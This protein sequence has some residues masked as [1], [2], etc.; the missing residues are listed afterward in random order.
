MSD[1]RSIITDIKK[2]KFAPV[3][4]LM[5]EEGYYIDLIAEALESNVVAEEDKEFDSIILYGSDADAASVLEAAGRYPMLSE[6]FFVAL[7]EAQTMFKAKMQMENLAGYIARPN[8]GTI[9]CITYKGDKL[10]STSDFMKAVKKNKDI[11]FFESPKIREYNM[12]GVVSDI[13]RSKNLRIADDAVEILVSFV[14][15]SITNL[16]SELDKLSLLVDKNDPV[17]TSELVYQNA[18]MS[19]EFNDFELTSALLRRDYFQA[20]RIVKYFEVNP[21]EN[22]TAKTT[23]IIFSTFQKLIIAAFS[24]DKTDKALMELLELKNS[25]GL[26]DIRT[27]LLKYNAAQLVN[28]IHYIREFDVMSKGVGSMQNEYALLTDLVFKIVTA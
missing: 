7:K 28:I 26:R 12:P 24:K 5:G 15:N 19:K 3:Y 27:G 23:G 4:V 9:L 25:Y 2:K 11:V 21:R 8:P 14:G 6:K 22:P 18:G 10:P 16:V 20:L 13:C 17:I 1:F